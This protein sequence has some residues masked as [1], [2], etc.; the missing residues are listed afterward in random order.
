[1]G[2]L[3]IGGSRKGN[4]RRTRIFYHSTVGVIMYQNIFCSMLST[5]LSVIPTVVKERAKYY[6]ECGATLYAK[7]FSA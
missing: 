2:C 5:K 7:L 1:M 3:G 6:R 4:R